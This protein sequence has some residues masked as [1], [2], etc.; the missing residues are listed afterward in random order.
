MSSRR[1]G[2]TTGGDVVLRTYV[3]YLLRRV[4]ARSADLERECLGDGAGL[5]ELAVLATLRRDGPTSQRRLGDLLHVNRTVMVKLVDA[6]EA[7]GWVVR[8]RNA[9][10]RRSYALQLTEAGLRAL[11]GMDARLARLESQLTDGLDATERTRLTHHLRTLLA[12]DEVVNLEGVGETT[13]FLVTHSYRALRAR[14]RNAFA[15]LGIEPRDFGILSVVAA[16]QPCSQ[17]EV[18]A[19][20]G[21]TPPAVQGAIDALADRGFLARTSFEADRRVHHLSLTEQGGDCLRRARVAAAEIQREVTQ[22]LGADQEADLRD[23]LAKVL[24]VPR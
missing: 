19:Q 15:D 16:R 22:L 23:L 4:Y 21:V 6:I 20:I 13:A 8:R 10:D 3:G 18:A 2:A 17:V 5:R 1:A 12:G 14:S 9:E 24:A 7:K 11:G